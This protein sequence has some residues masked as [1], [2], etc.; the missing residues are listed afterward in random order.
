MGE[1]EEE[2]SRGRW[3]QREDICMEYGNERIGISFDVIVGDGVAE[4]KGEDDAQQLRDAQTDADA[5]HHF[6]ILRQIIDHG[7]VTALKQT[8]HSHL[9]LFLRCMTSFVRTTATSSHARLQ[10]DSIH[11]IFRSI[12]NLDE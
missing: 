2:N 7:S 1:K 3:R 12:I 4:A 6:Q 8:N 9:S 5:H 11:P 10:L